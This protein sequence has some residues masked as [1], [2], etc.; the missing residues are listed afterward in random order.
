MSEAPSQTI[1]PTA[2]LEPTIQAPE[3]N[4][5]ERRARDDLRRQIA[6]LE[7]QLGELFGSAFPRAGL[8]WS[9][10]AVGGPR[11]LSIGDLERVRDALAARLGDARA[12]LGRRTEA[13]TAGRERL[14]AMIVAPERHRW[15]VVTQREIGAPGCGRW[16]S[17]PRWGILGMLFG[18]WRVRLSSGCPLAEGRP[19]P[20]DS[21]TKPADGEAAP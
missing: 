5:S 21:V 2:P 11:V 1:A 10:G 8:D 17:R 12:E 4:D 19:P 16:E 15:E 20:T 3:R 7:L 18:W 9:V 13:E 14:E 6:R